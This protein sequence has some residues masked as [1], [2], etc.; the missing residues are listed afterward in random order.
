MAGKL[1]LKL[2]RGATHRRKFRW[3]VEP[4]IY[5]QITGM[6][7]TA[8]LRLTVVGHGLLPNQTF[9]IQ[10]VVGMTE[11]N[12]TG[13]DTDWHPATVIDQDTIEL[14]RVNASAF[15]AY[16][17]GGNIKYRTVVDPSDYAVAMQIKNKADGE[18]LLSLTSAAGDF[19]VDAPDKS[20]EMTIPADALSTWKKGVYDI[21][22]TH[23]VTSE[24]VDFL[25]GEVAVIFDLTTS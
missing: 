17:S 12:D 8:P 4:F 9:A 21:E 11:L 14:N 15:K 10:S 16:V 18:T 13:K 22:L 19:V 6:S 3:E 2:R 1:N 23:T 5:K 24:V 20:I 25:F 7:Q